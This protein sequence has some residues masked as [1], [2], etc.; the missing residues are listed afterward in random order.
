MEIVKLGNFPH[1]SDFQSNLNP[2]I[3]HGFLHNNKV[4][5]S[6]MDLV[7]NPQQDI[8]EKVVAYKDKLKCD[9]LLSCFNNANSNGSTN[10]SK[11]PFT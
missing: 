6:T 11:G 2:E 8:K 1:F 10:L 4:K 5:F 9:K 3:L 7:K